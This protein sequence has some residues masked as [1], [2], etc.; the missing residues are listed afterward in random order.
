MT[1]SLRRFA[2]VTLS[3]ACFAA[4]A[5]ER[6]PDALEGLQRKDGFFEVW[7]DPAKGRVLLGLERLDTPL[8]LVTSLPH[9][10]G[11]NDVG[12]DR[13]QPGAVREVEFRRAGPRVLLVERNTRYQASAQNTAERASAHE[14]FAESVLWAG[15]ALQSTRSERVLVD[16]SSFLLSDRHGVAERLD[17]AKQGKYGIDEKRSAVLLDEARSFPDNTE[18][19]ALL[20]F[21][22]A[23]E[24]E[25]VRQ[26]SMDPT[27]LS[28]RQHLSLV[29]LPP[30]GFRPRRYHPASG[31][32]SQGVIDFSQPL[33]A[34]L[35]VRVQPRFRLEKTDPTAASSPVKKP[36]VFYLD[37]GT[38]EPVRSAL[39]D[40]ANWWKR[41]FEQAGYQDAFRAELLPEGVDA[42]DI[43]YNTILWVHRATRGW[44]YGAALTDPRTGE[45]IKGAVT[46][47]SQRVR[48][49]ILIAEALLAPYAR[50]DGAPLAQRAQD[51]ALARLRQLAAHEVGHALGFA[52]NFAASRD[53]S[54]NG[55]VL[56]YPHPMLEL[57]DGQGHL[58]LQNAYGDRI[59][60]WDEFL[61]KH[62]Y[63]EFPAEQEDAALAELRRKA[64]AAGLH[65]VSD[66]DA[67]SPGAAHPDGLLWDYGPSSLQTFDQLLKL[68]RRALERFDRGVLPPE[69]QLGEYEARLVPIYL[70]HRYQTEAVARLLGGASYRY[71]LAGDTTP[72]AAPVV[73]ADQRAALER[74]LRTLSATELTLPA[75]VLDLLTPPGNDYERTREYFATRSGPVFDPLAAA[76]AASAQTLQFLFDPA[77]LN[78]LAWQRARD[79]TQPG[80]ADVL[81]GAFRA[82]WQ[83]DT[84]ADTLPAAAAV[85]LSANWTTLDAALNLLE[86][87]QLHA[88][89]DADVRAELKRWQ[90]W[91]AQNTAAAG[92]AASRREAAALIGRYLADPKSVKL[93]PLPPIPPGA[94]I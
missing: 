17:Q 68:R 52:H 36:I 6:T 27:A 74:L 47:G 92:T 77:R 3:I 25:F 38:P 13:G 32:F 34:S 35:D 78:R 66:A 72:G 63:G 14:A 46:L 20:T 75:N 86:T 12:L 87:G 33:A 49:D 19:E 16:F 15:D 88:Q 57:I 64:A 61:V 23:G 29:R 50:H 59:G 45:I 22:G 51:M 54:G 4:V 91:L 90:Q 37:P 79:A 56:D 44:S 18:L 60:A 10:L 73:A 76:A 94:P 65:Y 31:G 48:Q 11:S 42:M 85:Q 69:R 9:G 55:S 30:E 43:R 81:S 39:L 21:Q 89:V 53:D 2:A 28:L 80:V 62:A 70:L 24:G 82:T 58:A 83:R 1:V 84:A 5:A 71:G 40:G 41:A 8:L 26:V 67:R 93:R 7:S